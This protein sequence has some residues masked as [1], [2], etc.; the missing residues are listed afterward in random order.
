MVNC[1]SRSL[2]D[3]ISFFCQ[4]KKM[5]LNQQ[6]KKITSGGH[7]TNPIFF[8]AQNDSNSSV[9]VRRFQKVWDE[10]CKYRPSQPSKLYRQSEHV[11]AT[12]V[13]A[14]QF[15]TAITNVRKEKLGKEEKHWQFTLSDWRSCKA[16][17]KRKLVTFWIDF[18]MACFFF[19]SD[20]C[21][22]FLLY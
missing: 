1:R 11:P 16:M 4:V 15:C 7:S 17:T 3:L 18:T 10:I 20:Y 8:P 14:I 21:S 22:V 6:N 9:Q 12:E 2:W 5:Y 19:L 13:G